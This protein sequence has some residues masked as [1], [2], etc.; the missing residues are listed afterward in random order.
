MPVPYRGHR[1]ALW[2]VGVLGGRRRGWDDTGEKRYLGQCVCGHIHGA[3]DP[4]T[5][6]AGIEGHVTKAI[7][8]GGE[9]AIVRRR[10]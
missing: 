8:A 6:R 2:S 7:A 4:D 10:T 1:H 3:G 5:A 9:P